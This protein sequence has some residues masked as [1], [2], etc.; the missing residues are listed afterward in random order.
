MK[1]SRHPSLCVL[2]FDD[3]KYHI[4]TSHSGITAEKIKALRL[5]YPSR[6]A[7][8]MRKQW[9][10]QRR[11]QIFQDYLHLLVLENK[12]CTVG[13]YYVKKQQPYQVPEVAVGYNDSAGKRDNRK[14]KSDIDFSA[15]ICDYSVMV[16]SFLRTVP[17]QIDTH[18]GLFPLG[19]FLPGGA[20][21]RGR[22]KKL[23]GCFRIQ[24]CTT[25]L[26]SSSGINL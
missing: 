23:I 13:D 25:S 3:T 11:W 24:V 8:N 2:W 7:S 17:L 21:G 12:M 15:M 10:V 20:W 4:H 16:T 19:F 9:Y 6:T 18:L 14:C 1:G 5:L 22:G 26:T